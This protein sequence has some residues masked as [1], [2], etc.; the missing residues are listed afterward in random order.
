MLKFYHADRVAETLTLR[1]LN[2]FLDSYEKGYT[3]E[4]YDE[5]VDNWAD[6]DRELRAMGRS[7]RASLASRAPKSKAKP[8]AASSARSGAPAK[9]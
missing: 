8:K 9:E 5:V 2:A 7:Y 4:Y 6:V 1:Q 3:Q